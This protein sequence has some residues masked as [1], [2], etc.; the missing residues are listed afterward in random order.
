MHHLLKAIILA[1]PALAAPSTPVA[2][3]DTPAPDA[4]SDDTSKNF[5]GWG[6]TNFEFHADYI[7]TTPAHQNSW[8]YVNFNVTSTAT[9]AVPFT[10]ACSG[11]SNQLSD[12]FFGTQIFTCPVPASAG[13]GHSGEV[14]FTFNRANGA[15]ALNQTWTCPGS[16]PKYPYVIHS[17]EPSHSSGKPILLTR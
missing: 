10:V 7:F 16:D 1:A 14:S 13:G 6:L 8:G 12:F 9:V 3:R 4:C 5:K 15:V 17:S 2:S 11:Q